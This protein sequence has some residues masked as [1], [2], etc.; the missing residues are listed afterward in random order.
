MVTSNYKFFSFKRFHIEQKILKILDILDKRDHSI[1]VLFTTDHHI[2][3]LNHQYRNINKAT[4]VLSFSQLEGEHMGDQ[5]LLGDVVISVDTARRNAKTHKASLESEL[6]LLITHGILHLLGYDH[7]GAQ[8]ENNT[9]R[10]LESQILKLI[11]QQKQ[12][13]GL[14][15]RATGGQIGY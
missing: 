2:K 6:N 9:M 13:E 3:E 11:S 4:D 15:E 10:K 14:V 12:S 8:Q 5:K 1:S 7:E